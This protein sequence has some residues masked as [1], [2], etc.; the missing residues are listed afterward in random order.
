MGESREGASIF[1]DAGA[2]G[3][4]SKADHSPI[5]RMKSAL[6]ELRDAAEYLASEL[7]PVEARK[8]EATAVAVLVQEASRAG[9]EAKS[10]LADAV[11]K[12]F[13]DNQDKVMRIDAGDGL[14]FWPDRSPGPPKPK[15]L[16]LII[17]EVWCS[18]FSQ[19]VIQ[20]VSGDIGAAEG[21]RGI[22][23]EIML[24][25]LSTN[26][27]KP[28]AI[29]HTLGEDEYWRLYDRPD[30]DKMKQGKPPARLGVGVERFMKARGSRGVQKGVA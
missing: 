27:F 9:N 3:R 6:T 11:L 21:V 16:K 13:A 5:G 14:F 17:E 25:L 23:E 12:W 22:F 1:E 24:S 30:V 2:E 18:E 20:L 28:G 8:E 19:P 29:K 15:D 26:A 7:H 4:M 10:I